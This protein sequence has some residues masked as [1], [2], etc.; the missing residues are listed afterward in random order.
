MLY[1]AVKREWAD[2]IRLV[3]DDDAPTTNL[4]LLHKAKKE[5]K[6]ERGQDRG[7]WT[8]GYER[9]GFDDDGYLVQAG[10]WLEHDEDAKGV[11]T[12][13]TIGTISKCRDDRTK[14]GDTLLDPTF[15]ELA[16]Y[17]TGISEE[18]WFA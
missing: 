1:G 11:K 14:V 5:Y 9:Q 4:I 13:K 6:R 7:D 8:G 17:V 16:E 3:Y 18:K 15:A 10:L 12:G 2:L